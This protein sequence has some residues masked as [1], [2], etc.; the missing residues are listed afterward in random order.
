MEEGLVALLLGAAPISA[1]IGD[2]LFPKIRKQ[3]SRLPCLVYNVFPRDGLI[4]H[5][6]PARVRE[7]RVQIDALGKTYADAKE[8]RRAVVTLLEGYR[9]VAGGVTF[10]GIFSAGGAGDSDEHVPP[11]IVFRDSRDFIVWA[12][13]A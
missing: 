1:K 13:E 11:E 7:F 2:R 4:A 6:G 9:G 10:Q 12:V 5:D 3:G 8:L